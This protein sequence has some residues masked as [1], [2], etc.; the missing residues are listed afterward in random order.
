MCVSMLFEMM[1]FRQPWVPLMPIMPWSTILFVQTVLSQ[2][3]SMPWAAFSI[4]FPE[5]IVWCVAS[6]PVT[7]MAEP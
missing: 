6:G 2:C 4:W 1:R 7:T 3:R 5:T